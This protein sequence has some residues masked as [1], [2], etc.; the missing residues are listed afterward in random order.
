VKFCWRSK[1]QNLQ[2]LP[3]IL[4]Q[5]RRFNKSQ[6]HLSSWEWIRTAAAAAAA[7]AQALDCMVD[8]IFHPS[9]RYR[10]HG[11]L[12][13]KQKPSKRTS[14]QQTQQSR[15]CVT[16]IWSIG[17][18][19]CG[20]WWT[21]RRHQEKKPVPKKDRRMKLSVVSNEAMIDCR[22]G[23]DA[24]ERN[25]TSVET[26]WS[27]PRSGDKSTRDVN[28]QHCRVASRHGHRHRQFVRTG[29]KAIQ[30]QCLAATGTLA[31]GKQQA[32][33]ITDHFVRTAS[34]YDGWI[35]YVRWTT[36]FYGTHW[37][38]Q[39]IHLLLCDATTCRNLWLVDQSMETPTAKM[40]RL[41]LLYS[42]IKNAAIQL[43][44]SNVQ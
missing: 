9:K 23:N 25:R 12:R 38:S 22:R 17:L 44:M 16:T 30:Q 41:Q 39:I 2:T 31:P 3:F 14:W 8:S 6:T 36:A 20:D 34:L 27:A 13:A 29:N 5:R 4:K 37:S 15:G 43:I 32:L 1:L 40:P 18:F 7:M 35:V 11:W 26:K 21:H 42:G 28:V 19:K 10:H 33:L 24:T